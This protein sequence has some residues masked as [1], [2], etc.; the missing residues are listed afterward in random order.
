L[1]GF[2]YKGSGAKINIP[3]VPKRDPDYVLKDKTFPNQAILYRINSD[4]NPLHADPNFAA[5][6]GF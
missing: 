6:A 3:N 5:L 2:G 1:G 4:P